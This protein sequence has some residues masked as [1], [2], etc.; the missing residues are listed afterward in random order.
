MGMR[1]CV[2]SALAVGAALG[3]V[4]VLG[5]CGGGDDS[6]A[7]VL[8][9]PLN[10]LEGVITRD[11]VELDSDVSS[12]GGGSLKITTTQ[13]ETVLLFETGDID[14]ED[15]RLIYQARLRTKDL[16]GL[17]YLEMWCHFPGMGDAFSRGLHSTLSG[18]NEWNTRETPFFLREGEN[19]DN[20]KLN[21]VID[22]AGIVWVDDIRLV[23]GPRG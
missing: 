17:A 11:G 12:D 14:I 6:A 23:K 8:R 9:Y 10:D 20:V 1:S 13:P 7:V 16:Q 19:P 4:A 18:T 2:L 22:G 15:A 21:L 3:L 5:G